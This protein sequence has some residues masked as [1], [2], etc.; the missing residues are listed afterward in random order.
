MALNRGY[1]LVELI[2]VLLIFSITLLLITFSFNRI[3]ASSGQISKGAETDIGGLIGLE[4]FRGDL[5]LAGLGLPWSLPGVEY[6]EAPDA[7]NLVSGCPDG[8]PR[9]AA[10]LFNDAGSP[11][12][13]GN[14]PRAYVVGEGVG[15][16]GSDYLVLKGTSL[17]MSL[18]A[19]SWSYLNYSSTGP[20]IKPARSEIELLPGQGDR[21][22]VLRPGMAQDKPTRALVTEAGKFSLVF[23]L[24]LPAAFRPEQAADTL[25]VYGIAPADAAPLNFPFNRADY[26]IS[27]PKDISAN[28]A[29]G[30][31]TL[32]KATINQNGST[33]RY[34]LL[35]CV[36]DL[37]SAVYLNGWPPEKPVNAEVLRGY[38]KEVRVYLLAQQGRRDPGFSYPVNDPSAALVVGGRPWSAA[39]LAQ[40]FGA[41]WR[42]YRWKIYSIVVQPKNL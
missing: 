26:F 8:C 2:V 12:T 3:L 19:R 34:P 10:R 17:G 39:E 27:R 42:N 23:D 15:L 22:I 36:A 18:T 35:D 33:T 30:T 29:P 14:P 9:A 13:P 4:L 7:L 21:V 37:Q 20:L 6:Q 11:G 25:L 24:P 41:Q 1:S 16:N 31:G 40:S 32:Y 38:L 28:C 5:E